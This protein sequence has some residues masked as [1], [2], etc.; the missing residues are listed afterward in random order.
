MIQ[1]GNYITKAN[2]DGLSIAQVA[3]CLGRSTQDLGQLCGDVNGNGNAGA[4]ASSFKAA[5]QPPIG[6]YNYRLLDFDGYYHEAPSV[7][8]T[9]AQNVGLIHND[10]D[11]YSQVIPFYAFFKNL[12]SYVNNKEFS[13]TDGIGTATLVLEYSPS[14]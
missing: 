11:Q 6:G 1:N 12:S 7:G 5:Y 9:C 14:P 2:N 3:R 10:L 4:M 13:V 8:M